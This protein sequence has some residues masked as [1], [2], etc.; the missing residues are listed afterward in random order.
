MYCI[1][2]SG[3]PASG[4]TVLAEYLSASLHIP[5]VSKD[6]IKEILFDTIGFRFR[7][8]KVALGTGAMETMYYFAGQMMRTGQPFLLENNFENV[9]RPGIQSLLEKYGYQAVTVRLTGDYNVLFNR[10][11]E[12]NNSPDRHKGHIV[13]DYY[14]KPEIKLETNL[15]AKANPVT[16]LKTKPEASP[17]TN[18]KANPEINQKTKPEANPK[19]KTKANPEIN[20]KTKPEANPET[21]TKANL[22]TNPKTKPEGNPEINPKT[23][24]EINIQPVLTQ[25]EF[26]RGITER[27]MVE[28][29]LPG[30][31]MEIDTTDF[32]KVD[33]R[34]VTEE[35]RNIISDLKLQ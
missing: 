30:P 25:E 4:K 3:I 20:Q 34:H 2:V 14:Q 19:T 32:S 29:Q 15:K 9:S 24:P 35:L 31:V 16:N 23:N 8:E 21:K 11:I 27:G 1:L 22:V 18:S 26:I 13:N 6:K 28:F 33:L 5:V 10:M 7:T 12:R 17:E